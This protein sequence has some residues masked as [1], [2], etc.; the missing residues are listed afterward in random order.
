MNNS[1][2]ALVFA[3]YAVIAGFFVIMLGIGLYYSGRMRNMQDYFSGGRRVPWWLSGTSFFMSSFSAFTF[4]SY[5]ELAYKYGW[6][7]VTLYWVTVP[8][9]LIG[10]YF[11][12]VRWRRA[13]ATSPLEYIEERYSSAL[14]QCLAWLGIPVKVIDDGL[15]LFAIGALVSSVFGFGM[16]TAILL[17]GG[18]MLAYTFLGGLWAVLVTDFVQFVILLAAVLVLIP[19][20]F[21]HVGS[22]SEFVRNAPDGFFNLTADKYDW[23]YLLTFF[24]IITLNY[25]TS[26]AL[27][28]RYYS[29]RNE[30]DARK[31]GYLVAVLNVIGP[32]LFF[33]PAMAARFFLPDVENTKEIYAM[34]CQTLLPVGMVGLLIAAMFSATMSMLSSD[35]NSA[36][37]VLTND[38][39]K[40]LISPN[41]SNRILV[42]AGRVITLII[43]ILSLGIAFWIVGNQGE[44]DLFE[45]M[46]KLFGVFLPPIAIPMLLGLISRKVNN[47]GGMT[48]LLLGMTIGLIAFAAGGREEYAWL[49]TPQII[50]L[51]TGGTAIFGVLI[52]TLG[53]PMTSEQREQIQ[54]FFQRLETSE[55]ADESD[56]ISDRHSVSPLPVIGFSIGA[57]GL[58]L[59]GVVLITVPRGE[60]GLSLAMGAGL[61]AI[62]AVVLGIRRL[63][64][65][66]EN[67]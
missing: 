50:T 2:R 58:L 25:S 34:L 23:F 49:R 24:V 3:D 27:V 55:P 6:V 67:Q 53:W 38:V 64:S 32:P 29:A 21:S 44:G 35:Y 61:V 22:V 52:G 37:A 13:A 20:A 7:S 15:K 45:L 41:A 11:F 5:S 46:V 51:I 19:L 65:K 8:A 40:R 36:A 62:G 39:Y 57:L 16:K 66:E 1:S 30:R 28:Q 43:G 26:W 63:Q 48:G 4:V 56:R 33:A 18:I 14:R 54:A 12:A 9:S 17:S 31:T 42:F 59:F 60:R 10:A 47:A